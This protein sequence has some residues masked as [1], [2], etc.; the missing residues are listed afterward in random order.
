MQVN[1]LNITRIHKYIHINF[2]NTN[3]THKFI[4]KFINTILEDTN[5]FNIVKYMTYI[6]EFC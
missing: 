3:G 2:I 1:Y 5:S 6:K 4:H